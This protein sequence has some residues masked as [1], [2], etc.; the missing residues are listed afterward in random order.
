MNITETDIYAKKI[1]EYMLMHHTPKPMEAI[2]ALGSNDLRVAER[3][4]E[5]YRQGF[6]PQ[7][8]CSGGFGKDR[9]F[10]RAEA[11]MFQEV[12]LKSGVSQG[13]IILE[14]ESTN[15]GENILF[16]KILLQKTGLFF[17]SFILVTK[18]YMERRA[19]ATFC[20]QWP[21]VECLV[22]SPQIS[23]EEYATDEVFRGLFINLMVGDLLRIKEYPAQG[24]QIHQDIPDD[25]WEAYEKLVVLGYNKYLV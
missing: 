10:S 1:W 23:Y 5:L 20:K 8:I 7:V 3:A 14:S 25:V 17:N 18:P 9:F 12:L 19:Y 6:A 13:N 15:T 24:F 22:T 4:S 11:E 21:N 2:I 16:T